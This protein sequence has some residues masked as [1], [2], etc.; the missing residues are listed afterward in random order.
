M[1]EG[2][3]QVKTGAQVMG[4]Q[5]I[6]S[7]DQQVTGEVGWDFEGQAEGRYKKWKMG[8]GIAKPGSISTLV[9]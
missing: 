3:L 1:G 7:P 4:G 6:F 9:D 5:I 8:P 2:G